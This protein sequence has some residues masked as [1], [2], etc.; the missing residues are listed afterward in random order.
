MAQGRYHLFEGV[1]VIW[2]LRL[3]V[4]GA[5]ILF[6]ALETDFSAIW[7]HITSQV[8][9]GLLVSQPVI[10]LSYGFF[11]LRLRIIAADRR[12]PFR[13]AFTAFIL[14][15]GLNIIV[16]ARISEF[17]KPVYLRSA[18]GLPISLG[19]SLLVIERVFDIL[20]LG[21]S[22]LLL[23]PTSYMPQS[24][25]VAIIVVC[26]GAAGAPWIAAF[27]L[28]FLPP[29]DNK[30]KAAAR[31]FIGTIAQVRK[32]GAYFSVLTLSAGGW[33]TSMLS[34]HVALAV[35]GS[36]T[37]TVL[38]TGILFLATLAGGALAILPAGI[39][40]FQAAAIICL[41]GFGFSK[42]ESIVLAVM[43]HV[44]AL[45]YACLHTI[46]VVTRNGFDLS[47]IRNFRRPK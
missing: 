18:C 32:R 45:I 46:F 39:G 20:V 36:R 30:I 14:P 4:V 2:I 23:L 43:L 3:V 41:V 13:E 10:V 33:I 29:P 22:A 12:L 42:E 11:A 21:T 35:A 16:P 17:S 8:F 25:T 47:R 9:F 1:A 6:I 26:L 28:G 19:L 40:T 37:L 34:L 7:Q 31:T 38:E 5:I 15:I 24:T 44:Q 27:A